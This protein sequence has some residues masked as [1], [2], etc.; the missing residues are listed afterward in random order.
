ML[1][2]ISRC[3]VA[4]RNH[5]NEIASLIEHNAARATLRLVSHTGRRRYLGVIYT[6]N[7]TNNDTDGTAQPS[8]AVPHGILPAEITALIAR[9]A[10]APGLPKQARL[11]PNSNS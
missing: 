11:N 10:M 9:Y 5:R 1:L 6:N 3:G 2:Y 4:V 8:A 7:N